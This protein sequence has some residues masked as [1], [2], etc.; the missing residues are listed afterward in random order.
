M[1]HQLAKVEATV[2][3]M[4]QANMAGA[5]GLTA[6]TGA[7]EAAATCRPSSEVFLAE[8][9]RILP[10]LAALRD[11]IDKLVLALGDEDT[12]SG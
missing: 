2:A 9:R 10:S 7:I 6:F 3:N 11:A 5:R 1:S 8:A 4:V 12:T